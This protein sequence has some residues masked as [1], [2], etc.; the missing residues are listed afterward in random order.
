MEKKWGSSGPGIRT[1][2][3]AFGKTHDPSEFELEFQK[4]FYL[5]FIWEGGEKPLTNKGLFSIKEILLT[6]YMSN[7]L[8]ERDKTFMTLS[9]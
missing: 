1:A 5:F 3:N 4:H 9:Y 6:L 2:N 8:R 7:I